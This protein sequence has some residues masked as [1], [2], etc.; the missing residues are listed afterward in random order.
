M[1]PPNARHRMNET[2]RIDHAMATALNATLDAARTWRDRRELDDQLIA[3][4][5]AALE[6]LRGTPVEVPPVSQPRPKLRLVR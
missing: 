4:A 2:V 1:K 5:R 6:A 3:R